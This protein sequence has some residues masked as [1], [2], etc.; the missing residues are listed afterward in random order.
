MMYYIESPSNDPRFNLALEQYVFE[1]LDANHE[2]FMLW[3]NRNSIIIGKHQNTVEEI[4]PVYIKEHD[5]QVV[6]R[7]SGG[8]AVYHDLGNINFTFITNK[9]GH[10]SFD[11]ALFC[12]P[13]INALHSLGAEAQVNGRND[14]TLDGKKF[15]G[16]SQYI[17]H[18]RVMHHGTIMFDSDLQV[19]SQALKVPEDKIV[20]KGLKS[21]RSRVTNV[22][23]YLRDNITT[24][25]FL[26]RIRCFMFEAFSLEPYILT[27]DDIA[28]VKRIQSEVYD[29]WSWNYGSSPAYQICKKRRVE[30]CGNIEV[31]MNVTQGKIENIAFFGDYFGLDDPASLIQLLLDCELR[32]DALLERL[33]H[34][35]ISTFFHNMDVFTFCSILLQ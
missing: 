10:A 33:S 7:L 11:F 26:V 23:P 2:Y 31:H 4:N 30:N 24:Q 22:K 9:G 34:T 1:Q 17:K 14:M 19:L 28:S 29:Q 25:E 5:I 35:D 6:R 18:N 16:N 8:G 27:P 20:S 15:S 3:Q 21:V 12:R 32:E 13:V